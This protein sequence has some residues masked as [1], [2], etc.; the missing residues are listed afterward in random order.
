VLLHRRI[1]VSF[2]HRSHEQGLI[3]LQRR[4]YAVRRVGGYAGSEKGSELLLLTEKGQ[5][6]RMR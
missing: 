4:G 5:S 6:G 3:E 1:V 2:H